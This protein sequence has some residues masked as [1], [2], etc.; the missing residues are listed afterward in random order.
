MTRLIKSLCYEG[1]SDNYVDKQ[2]VDNTTHIGVRP[3][4]LE[5][6]TS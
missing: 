6:K 3:F 2:F 5:K 1:W 4:L